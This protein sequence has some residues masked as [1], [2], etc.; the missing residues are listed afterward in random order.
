MN[1]YGNYIPRQSEKL[2]GMYDLSK[3]E[4]KIIISEDVV[5]NFKSI[6][7]LVEACG[8]ALRQ[9]LPGKQYV[10]MTDASFRSSGYAL[11]MEEENDERKFSSK[12]KTFAP[13]AFGSKV[14]TPSQLKM[15][16]YCRE[17]LALYHAF[18]EYSHIL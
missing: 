16:I 9:P 17:F 11:M 13:D 10:L 18:M 6:N 1:Y 3:A 2:I 5:D 12:K 15:S 7:V 8:L 14:F 4:S